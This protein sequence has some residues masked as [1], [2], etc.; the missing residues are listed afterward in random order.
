MAGG[1]RSQSL[2]AL[3]LVVHRLAAGVTW[4]KFSHIALFALGT[5]WAL[6]QLSAHHDRQ[7][8]FCRD[9]MW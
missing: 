6:A 9:L 4:R 3:G 2:E 1:W 7:S 8:C 5:P